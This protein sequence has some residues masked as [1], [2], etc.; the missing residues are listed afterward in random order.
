MN[1]Q[2]VDFILNDLARIFHQFRSLEYMIQFY[3]IRHD[4]G[5]LGNESLNRLRASYISLE[6][7]YFCKAVNKAIAIQEIV[8]DES[9]FTSVDDSF[10]LLKKIVKRFGFSLNIKQW[11]ESLFRL[12]G[13]FVALFVRLLLSDTF[14]E[15]LAKSPSDPS[16]PS[17]EKTIL[18]SRDAL[19]Q[20]LY[21]LYSCRTTLLSAPVDRHK[22]THWP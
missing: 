3:D 8:F 11:S 5:E 15:S 14:S 20:C 17:P 16:A 9:V 22:L 12:L 13:D 7:N 1:L 6:R 21:H 4:H 18:V 2:D 10:F 19:A